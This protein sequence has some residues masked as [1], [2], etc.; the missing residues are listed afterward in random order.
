M[1]RKLIIVVAIE[2]LS[3]IVKTTKVLFAI[4]ILFTIAKAIT[5]AHLLIIE[6]LSLAIAKIRSIVE[7][8]LDSFLLS[9]RIDIDFCLIDNLIY[10]VK[11]RLIVELDYDITPLVRP[12]AKIGSRRF[13]EIESLKLV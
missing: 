11:N 8:Q 7:A 4:N 5:K 9:R 10:Y 13:F 3:T 1:L 6:V 2:V 12:G